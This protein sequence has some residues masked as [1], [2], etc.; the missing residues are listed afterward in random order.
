MAGAEE[1]I[2]RRGDEER[3]TKNEFIGMRM[4]MGPCGPQRHARVQLM[5][6]I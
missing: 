1:E 5:E 4:R 2:R 3:G 6:V